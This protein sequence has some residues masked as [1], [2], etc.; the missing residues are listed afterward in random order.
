MSG[1]AGLSPASMSGLLHAL[2]ENPYLASLSY[3]HIIDTIDSRVIEEAGIK[4]SRFIGCKT[5]S[6]SSQNRSFMT[7]HPAIW[8]EDP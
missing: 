7:H 5:S 1:T 4:D 6:H 3:T 8:T 2:R